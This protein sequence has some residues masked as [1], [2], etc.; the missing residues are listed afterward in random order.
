MSR[1][2]FHGAAAGHCYEWGLRMALI[3]GH[4]GVVAELEAWVCA[5]RA[6]PPEQLEP[7]KP[8]GQLCR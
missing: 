5:N 2:G 4:A 3:A 7:S 1:Q 8:S 6:H